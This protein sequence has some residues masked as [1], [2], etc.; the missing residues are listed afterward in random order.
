M[1]SPHLFR[2]ITSFSLGI[3]FC[4][5]LR[6]AVLTLNIGPFLGLI[7]CLICFIFCVY[8]TQPLPIKNIT[9]LHINKTYKNV[10]KFLASFER[11]KN[12]PLH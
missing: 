5:I 3:C 2:H 12:E 11:D 6:E 1:N 4:L 8:I 7:I 9:Y 10:E